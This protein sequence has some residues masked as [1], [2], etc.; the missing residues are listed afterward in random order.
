[1]WVDK[2]QLATDEGMHEGVRDSLNFIL[3]MTEEVLKRRFCIQEIKWAIQYKKNIIIVFQTDPRHGGVTG[4]F[5]EYYDVQLQN[6]FP[7]EKEYKWQAT[8]RT[9]QV[10]NVT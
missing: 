3:Y 8:R 5:T 4:A 2:E 7:N 9:Y 10:D 1:M 6:A